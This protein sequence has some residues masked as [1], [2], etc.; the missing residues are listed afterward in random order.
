MAWTD[1]CKIQAVMTIDKVAE[2][3][4]VSVT[5][6][7]EA[8]SKEADI[9]ESTLKK[10][11]YPGE[12]KVGPLLGQLLNESQNESYAKNGATNNSTQDEGYPKTGVIDNDS[13]LRNPQNNNVI[14]AHP[15]SAQPTKPQDDQGKS[16]QPEPQDKQQP[17]SQTKR[18]AI[19][20]PQK[21]KREKSDDRVTDNF[22]RAFGVMNDAIQTE[23]IAGWSAMTRITALL[24][25]NALINLIK[26]GE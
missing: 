24:Y 7:I 26:V 13:I 9:P 10:W 23:R 14:T 25:A 8:V 18:E 21:P 2:D 11:Y 20:K 19:Q 16:E 1:Q 22:K 4:K 5:K 15:E 3:M 12:K 6:A 17:K